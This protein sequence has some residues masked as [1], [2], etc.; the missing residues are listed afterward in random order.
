MSG[1]V[2]IGGSASAPSAASGED[3]IDLAWCDLL[4]PELPT[5][6]DPAAGVT[7]S[8]P[9]QRAYE[10]S[11][12]YQLMEA[13]TVRLVRDWVVLLRARGDERSLALSERL[14]GQQVDARSQLVERARHSRDPVVYAW[15]LQGCGERSECD[16]LTVR[17]WAQLDPGNLQPWLHEA[18]R[19]R[20]VGDRAGLREALFQISVASRSDDYSLLFLQQL[21]GLRRTEQAG[22]RQTVELSVPVGMYAAQV[23]VLAAALTVGCRGAELADPNQQQLCAAVADSL[24]RNATTLLEQSLALT[25][26]QR[27]SQRG[28]TIWTARS[29]TLDAMKQVQA[30]MF[31]NLLAET[32]KASTAD[33][34]PACLDLTALNAHTRQLVQANERVRLERLVAAHD[35]AELAARWRATKAS[36]SAPTVTKP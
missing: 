13:A 9:G 25:M 4:Y 35:V 12:K 18:N 10:A 7:R 26:A 1:V 36:A 3:A 31:D 21:L 14:Q 22:L 11:P 6:S 27:L 23:N 20:Q 33:R 16:G 5:V 19:A 32:E 28:S 34:R 24:W 17:R 2:Q 30:D 15:A 29:L 8:A